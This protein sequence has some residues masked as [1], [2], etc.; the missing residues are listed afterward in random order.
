MRELT[1]ATQVTLGSDP[2]FV[3][4]VIHEHDASNIKQIDYVSPYP[5]D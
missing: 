5:I 2:K 4:V 1:E 3:N